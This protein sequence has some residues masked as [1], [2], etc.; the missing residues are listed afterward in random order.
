MNKRG[1][2]LIELVVV[3]AVIGVIGVILTNTLVQTLRGENKVKIINKAKEN[4]QVALD[5]M[6]YAIRNSDQVECVGRNSAN[7]S[8]QDDTLIIHNKSG[9]SEGFIRFRF[10]PPTS[11]TNGYIERNDFTLESLPVSG[12][13]TNCQANVNYGSNYYSLTDRDASQGIS[14]NYYKIG[15]S[16]QPIFT[17]IRKPGSADVVLIQFSVSSGVSAGSSFENLISNSEG[18]IVFSTS[19]AAGARSP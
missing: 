18:G 19:V 11:S 2:T 16:D 17:L 13:E 9:V 8:G 1:F 14:V 4:G 7:S 5:N 15:V 10:I 12:D 6:V 3:I